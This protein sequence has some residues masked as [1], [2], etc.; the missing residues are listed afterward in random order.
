MIVELPNRQELEFP[1]GTSK[2]VMRNAIYKHF[3]EYALKTETPTISEDIKGSI[4]G[5]PE[6]LYE[7]FTHLPKQLSES[8]SQI[9]NNPIRSAEN[10]GAGLLKG[11]KGGA[12][13]PSNVAAYLESR[14]IG[15]GKI[16]DFIKSLHIPDTG[17][18]KRILGENQAGDEFLR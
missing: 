14:G 16:E 13:I 11:L 3:P 2:E 17:L 12:N 9:Y 1:D 10:I 4:R 5:A 7:A 6:A 18:E 8:G 15:Q